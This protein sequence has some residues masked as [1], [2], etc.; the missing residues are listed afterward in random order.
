MIARAA[1]PGAPIAREAGM[2]NRAA[3][4]ATRK[5]ILRTLSACASASSK[6]EVT[7]LDPPHRLGVS[8]R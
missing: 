7:L 2:A 4:P 5:L 6:A 8:G 3:M 1:I